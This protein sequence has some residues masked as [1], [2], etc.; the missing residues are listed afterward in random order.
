M[1]LW[2]LKH[3]V[4]A[5]TPPIA[6]NVPWNPA[7]C[8][9]VC[10]PIQEP[11]ILN[12][13]RAQFNLVQT[14]SPP[15]QSWSR[16][17]RQTGLADPNEFSFLEALG[18]AACGQ[19]N[20][21][22]AECSDEL[23][24]H[25]HWP[26]VQAYAS[27]LGF[28][29]IWSQATPYHFLVN[30]MRTRWLGI[31]IRSD[32]PAKAF[33]FPVHPTLVPKASWDSQ[34]HEFPIPP[35]W[36]HQ[37]KLSDSECSFYD[38]EDFLPAAKRHKAHKGQDRQAHGL[39]S[40][41]PDSSDPMPTLCASYSRQHF[42]SEDHLRSKGIF[43]VLQ[44]TE[45][46]FAFFPPGLFVSMFGA[47]ESLVFPSKVQATFQVLG[48]AITVPHSVLALSIAFLSI[49]GEAIDP[50]QL[51]RQV[52]A[53]R[54]TAYN[55]V[56]FEQG[57][58]VHFVPRDSMHLW[59]SGKAVAASPTGPHIRCSGSFPDVH[60]DARIPSVCSGLHI[61]SHCLEGPVELI[62]Q[63]ALINHEVKASSRWSIQALAAAAAE[64]DLY[65]GYCKVGTCHLMPVEALPCATEVISIPDTQPFDPEHNFVIDDHAHLSFEDVLQSTFFRVVQPVIETLQDDATP[66]RCQVTIVD[67]S[68]AGP[69][70]I[71]CTDKDGGKCAEQ[72]GKL[73]QSQ[74]VSVSHGRGCL[75]ALID[76]DPP[77]GFLS[78]L[79][80]NCD[81]IHGSCRV[82]AVPASTTTQQEFLLDGHVSVVQTHN[83]D[84]NDTCNL[85]RHGDVVV[86]AASRR[87]LAGGHHN[88]VGPSPSLDAGSSFDARMEFMVNTHGWMASD[89]MFYYTQAL[90]WSGSDM[91]FSPPVLWDIAKQD[92]DEAGHGEPNFYNN[93]TTV[94][95][96]LVRS[97][98]GAAEITKRGDQ[99]SITFIQIHADF[100]ERLISILARFL[101]IAP[102]R[103]QIHMLPEYYRPHLC[104]WHLMMRW[105]S[106]GGHH[107]TIA[108]LS[109]QLPL[110]PAVNN[111][112]NEVMHSSREDWQ[113]ESI[114]Q[115]VG[116]L[117]FRL[118]KNFVLIL[119]HSHVQGRPRT[120]VALHVEHPPPPVVRTVH[121]PAE[122]TLTREQRIQQ[123]LAH[124]QQFR[125]WLATDELDYALEG[126]RALSTT[127]LFCAPAVWNTQTG[128]LAFLNDF[129]PEYAAFSHII[130]HI[131]VNNHW[132]AV[133]AYLSAAGANF[134]AT[135]PADMRE[136]LRPLFDHLVHVTEVDRTALQFTFLD[137]VAPA[138]MCGYQLLR[139]L[140]RRLEADQIA[141]N[142]TQTLQLQTSHWAQE[143]AVIQDEAAQLWEETQA[144]AALRSFAV[145]TRNWFLIRV[146]EN[147]FPQHYVAAG[148]HD[149]DEPMPEDHNKR[150]K[151]SQSSTISKGASK[152]A[153]DPWTSWD[154]WKAKTARPQQSKWEDLQLRSPLPF[155]GSDKKPL[156]QTHRLQL[157]AARGGAVMTTKS[158][159]AE[160]LKS[161]VQGDL[162]AILPAG[163]NG[164]LKHIVDRLEGPFEIALND[165]LANLSY[166]RLIHMLVIKGKI[167]FQLPEPVVKLTTPAIC[168]LVLEIDCRLV[169]RQEFER[170]RDNPVLAFKAMLADIDESTAD[171]AVLY[172]FRQIRYPG[173]QHPDQML[174]IIAKVPYAQRSKILEASGGGSLLTRDFLEKGKG[175]SDTTVL[176]RFWLPSVSEH[177]NM[178][179]AVKG[180]QGFAGVVMT[181]R[182]LAPRIW[183]AHISAARSHLLSADSRLTKDNIH[184]VPRHTIELAGWPAATAAEHVVSSTLQALKLAVIPLR[185]FRV[186][187]VHVWV[188]TTDSKP[189][190][191][192]F[193][194]QINAEI[195]EILV[196]EVTNPHP[197][198]AGKGAQKGKQKPKPQAQ[199]TW[200]FA[201][202]SPQPSKADDQRIDRLEQRF[203]KLE[204]K[205]QSF[206][207]KVDT[208]FGDIQDSLRQLLAHAVQR[209]REPTGETP[210]SKLLKSS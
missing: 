26:I 189:S 23:I 141:L 112:V 44:H 149:S 117:A 173:G 27:L 114:D 130:W 67:M 10:S 49:T 93:S 198:K 156:Q 94:L 56:V 62:R 183:V 48:N 175:S 54:L 176:P 83:G 178:K 97:H 155:I 124:F 98:W 58:F 126:P 123:R 72:L 81:D 17:G 194:V 24:R 63:I 147:R 29:L 143:V 193:S 150:P 127:T 110:P 160:V 157:T 73:H 34:A 36:K 96:I 51:V 15:C 79:A 1:K 108:D 38:S 154:P 146:L 184:V 142:P 53:S 33:D 91:K 16:G 46:G 208:R 84:L 115:G 177:Q 3:N 119:A 164:H 74:V 9:G 174:Q 75:L 151:G 95:P 185:T 111:L 42:L 196:Q 199:A 85:L 121:V 102:H 209:P 41:V 14:M 43:A 13:L 122:A 89:E 201:A 64:W 32:C 148:M 207:A 101:D 109:D 55:T 39:W 21:L 71:C 145:A 31:W 133:E 190:Q 52:W 60:F 100:R 188:V 68:K 172:G 118:R 47:T 166:K 202:S 169:S 86:F 69:I 168:E 163:E 5:L 129:I 162:V 186:G 8:V 88:N 138:N 77:A 182:G 116:E 19:P 2:S 59:I 4:N 82:I 70:S 179:I 203:E 181:K 12:L 140:F 204:A 45:C 134:G 99:T 66:R 107:Q 144:S 20:V 128:R 87:I 18:V 11:S 113:E 210:P 158:N 195:S 106:W 35:V 78:I 139:Q 170:I 40:R 197:P 171:Q 28:K 61:L 22:V 206:E 90:M 167:T 57:D 105:Y 137:Q 80:Y 187:G 76:R 125:G 92:F 152:D 159:V 7:E 6:H 192:S 50:L 165:P 120:Q 37:L 191:S 103:I 153:S 135:V 132:I 161:P 200:T 104:G 30:H 136:M 25:A 180:A 205:Q 65:V 131:V